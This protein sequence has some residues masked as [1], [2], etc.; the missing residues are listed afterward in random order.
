[1]ICPICELPAEEFD[2]PQDST[3][4]ICCRCK[5]LI[6]IESIDTDDICVEDEDLLEK[7]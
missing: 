7:E 3:R 5:T 2:E 1:M 4:Y 6:T